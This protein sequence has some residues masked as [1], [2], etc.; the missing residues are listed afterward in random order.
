MERS[1]LGAHASGSRVIHLGVDLDL[2]KPGLKSAARKKLGLPLEVP[3]LLFAASTVTQNPWKDYRTMQ[4][5][6]DI[7]CHAQKD[8]P[9]VFLAVGEEGKTVHSGLCETRFYPYQKDPAVMAC[10]YQAADIYLHAAR[11]ETFPLAPLEAQACGTPVIATGIGGIPEGIKGLKGV[12]DK[13][14]DHFN[15]H[16][17]LEA[18]GILIPLGQ[19][20]AL[21]K[22]IDV[23]LKQDGLRR[24]LGRN[25]RQEGESRFSLSRVVE[26]YLE[27]YRELIPA[28]S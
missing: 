16:D 18:T 21:A 8:N 23:L 13:E 17:S 25:A 27:Y 26:E 14:M 12:L 3:L 19:E 20:R 1:M 7:L 22:A 11:A 5:A 9:L 15:R 10:F 24:E 6:L 28:Y 4:A 2:F